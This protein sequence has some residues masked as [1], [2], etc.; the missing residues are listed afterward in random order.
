MLKNCPFAC[1]SDYIPLPHK[2]K[3][4]NYYLQLIK[5][6]NSYPLLTFPNPFM[7]DSEES[8]LEEN[9]YENLFLCK[10]RKKRRVVVPLSVTPLVKDLKR[11]VFPKLPDFNPLLYS[12]HMADHPDVFKKFH[13]ESVI[14]DW[15]DT[16]EEISENFV[17]ID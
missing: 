9:G 8:P 3:K 4:K 7:I 12:E 11:C 14:N 1:Q 16:T 13:S 10:K 15:E 5:D 6:A 2:T 17:C